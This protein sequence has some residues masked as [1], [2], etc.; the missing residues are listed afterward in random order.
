MVTKSYFYLIVTTSE[1]A[2]HTLDSFAVV[3]GEGAAVG[4]A[5]KTV[6]AIPE[7]DPSR[8]QSRQS[9]FLW[10]INPAFHRISVS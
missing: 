5:L 7:D 10:V 9:A 2:P 8:V 4:K 1:K 6:L 3:Q